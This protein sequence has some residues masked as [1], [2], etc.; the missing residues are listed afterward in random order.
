MR[1]KASLAGIFILEFVE[2]VTPSSSCPKCFSEKSDVHL[3]GFP[4]QVIYF[5]PLANFIMFFL[6]WTFGSFTS[7][8]PAVVLF[9]FFHYGDLVFFL[10]PVFLFSSLS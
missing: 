10:L 2:H 3:L 4:L 8:C 7:M 1:D 6:S 5:L 9:F